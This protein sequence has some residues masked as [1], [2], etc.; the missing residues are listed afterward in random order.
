M[1]PAS[2]NLSLKAQRRLE[3]A[4]LKLARLIGRRMAH[5]EISKATAQ[6]PSGEKDEDTLP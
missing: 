3:V 1:V 5:E 2:A 6:R 4:L